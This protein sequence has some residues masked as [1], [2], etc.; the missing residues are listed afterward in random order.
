MSLSGNQFHYF[1]RYTVAFIAFGFIGRWDLWP[2]LKNQTPR[3][4]PLPSLPCAS[5]RVKRLMFLIPD[6]VSTQS[7]KAFANTFEIPGCAN[8]LSRTAAGEIECAQWS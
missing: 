2:A 1:V 3:V 6:L 7:Q 8:S 4:S 5:F